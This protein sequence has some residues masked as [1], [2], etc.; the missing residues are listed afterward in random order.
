MKKILTTLAALALALIP[1]HA[2]ATADWCAVVRWSPDGFT[3]LREGP[4]VAFRVLG[5]LRPGDLIEVDTRRCYKDTCPSG[6]VHVT[7]SPR[8]HLSDG[9]I[10]ERWIQQVGCPEEA[11]R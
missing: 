8:T 1:S 5:K 10:S 2:C 6:W 7:F 11:A 3:N 4:G 9:W